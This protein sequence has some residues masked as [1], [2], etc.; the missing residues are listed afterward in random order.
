MR[1]SIGD[2]YP[3]PSSQASQ[4]DL[5]NVLPKIAYPRMQIRYDEKPCRTT[6]APYG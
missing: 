4:L 6:E 3:L 5:C 2:A 1:R